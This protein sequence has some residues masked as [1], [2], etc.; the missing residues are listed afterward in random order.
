MF[1]TFSQHAVFGSTGHRSSVACEKR[2]GL[3]VGLWRAQGAEKASGDWILVSG[4]FAGLVERPV[5]GRGCRGSRQLAGS[6]SLSRCC[7]C[8]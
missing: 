2:L 1:R 8:G 5:A 4:R 7:S 3:L 6:P